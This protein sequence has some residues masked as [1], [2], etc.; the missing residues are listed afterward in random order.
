MISKD[1][2]DPL[3]TPE[4]IIKTGITSLID[5]IGA[6]HSSKQGSPATLDSPMNYRLSIMVRETFHLPEASTAPR[7]SVS[8][9]SKPS[10]TLESCSRKESL[11]I[12]TKKT[13][14][15]KKELGNGSPGS[16]DTDREESGKSAFR[17]PFHSSPLH[18]ASAFQS[19]KSTEVGVA[20][21]RSKICQSIQSTPRLTSQDGPHILSPIPTRLS[22]RLPIKME[23]SGNGS[24]LPPAILESESK[25]L[26]NAYSLIKISS[27]ALKRE[28]PEVSK[29]EVGDFIPNEDEEFLCKHCGKL[30]TTGQAL[31]GHMSRKHSGKSSKYNYKKDVRKRREFERMKLYL[32]KIKYFESLGYDYEMMIR[33]PDG[34]MKAKNLINRSRIKKLKSL[35]SDEEVCNFFER[36]N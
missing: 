3:R 13:V 27:Q 12:S 16:K 18:Q 1:K 26:S 5:A 6:E 35:L 9:E 8:L 24:I 17:N 11:M 15:E 20:Y 36:T 23:E 31:G 19:V 22:I 14:E 29:N 7:L 25:T 34:K 2:Q 10:Q 30:F 21:L 4:H 28:H 33:T 32:A